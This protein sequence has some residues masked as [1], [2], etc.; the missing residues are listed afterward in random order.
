MNHV[1]HLA[2]AADP[3]RHQL[4][5]DLDHQTFWKTVVLGLRAERDVF[6]RPKKTFGRW[7]RF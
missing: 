2:V 4:A 7:V 6:E 1:L 5:S 3:I